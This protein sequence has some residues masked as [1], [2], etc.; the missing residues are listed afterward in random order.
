MIV[1]LSLHPISAREET[2]TTKLHRLLGDTPLLAVRPPRG[3]DILRLD[4][5]SI[6][7]HTSHIGKIKTQSDDDDLTCN[8][9]S[10]IDC[11][12]DG[13]NHDNRSDDDLLFEMESCSLQD[14]DMLFSEYVEELEYS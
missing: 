3:F 9:N 1:N 2:S 5:I 8:A 12:F 11:A 10:N 4:G 6:Q 7:F 14:E 13:L